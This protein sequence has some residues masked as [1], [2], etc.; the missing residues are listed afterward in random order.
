MYYIHASF[1]YVVLEEQCSKLGCLSIGILLTAKLRNIAQGSFFLRTRTGRSSSLSSVNGLST[2]GSLKRRADISLQPSDNADTSV[3]GPITD[4]SMSDPS[5]ADAIRRGRRNRL[6]RGADGEMLLYDGSSEDE[7]E[8]KATEDMNKPM[9]PGSEGYGSAVLTSEELAR[10]D[11]EPL[12]AASRSQKP[13]VRQRLGKSSRKDNDNESWIPA[14]TENPSISDITDLAGLGSWRNHNLSSFSLTS[15]SFGQV[16]QMAAAAQWERRKAA[17][18]KARQEVMARLERTREA[19]HRL[20]TARKQR[21]A[22]LTGELREIMN[23][24]N[25]AS[26]QPQSRAAQASLVGET[27]LTID[28]KEAAEETIVEPCDP[29]TEPLPLLNRSKLVETARRLQVELKKLEAEMRLSDSSFKHG[30]TSSGAENVSSPAVITAAVTSTGGGS[31]SLNSV[32]KALIS[33]LPESVAAERREAIEKVKNSLVILQTQLKEKTIALASSG[34][35]ADAESDAS[36]TQLRREVADFKRQLVNLE[37]IKLSD[38]AAATFGS[39]RLP[40]RVQT[41]LDKRPRTL[42]ITGLAPKDTDAFLNSLK[43]QQITIYFK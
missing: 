13:S 22:K 40:G 2:F 8:A 43:L 17:A 12:L 27:V 24:L 35:E 42:Y 14:L 41:K 33:V 21:L 31:G 11:D 19:R 32:G 9:L 28:T 10:S 1:D 39:V 3:C 5:S 18:L 20:E 23:Q 38:L 26:R 29:A 25:Q 36:I 15:G 16:R 6:E 34:I 4:E 37:T 30:F 7:D